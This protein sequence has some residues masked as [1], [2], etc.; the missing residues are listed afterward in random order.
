MGIVSRGSIHRETNGRWRARYR[1]PEGRDRSRSFDRRIDAEK[2]LTSIEHSK[3][4]GSYIDPSAGKVTFKSYAERW[5]CNQVHRKATEAQVETNLRL[6]VYPQIGHRAIA[7]I[8][9]SEI[10][11]LIKAMIDGEGTDRPLAP[12]TVKT[13]H[14]W[15]GTIFASAVSDRLRADSPCSGVRLPPVEKP[16]VVPWEV[17]RVNAVREA[18]PPRFRA[19]VVLGAGTGVRIS[20]AIGLTV[21]RVD[22]LRRTVTIDRQLVGAVDGKPVFGPVK[23]RKN[24][25]RVIPLPDVVLASL[26]EHLFRWQAGP[27]GLIFTNDRNRPIRRTTFSDIWRKAVGPLGVPSGD[28]YHQLRHFFA[29]LLISHGESVKV[30]QERLGHA[31]ALMT[32]DTYS[33][34]WPDS[35]D[36]T[37][38]AVVR[39]WEILLCRRRVR[40]QGRNINSL[41]RPWLTVSRPVGGIRLGALLG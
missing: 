28:G 20:E 24:R 34:L 13:I 39:S 22:F 30:V 27:D 8:H 15:V 10:Q 14:A 5:R 35:D 40:P 12:S 16:R 6:H 29:S 38:A 17:G 2:F 36:S 11:R 7:S 33:H 3:L 4:T 37:R 18:M 1:N 19:L 41:V 26:S 23:D 21:D 31:S 25:P 9:R 32:L